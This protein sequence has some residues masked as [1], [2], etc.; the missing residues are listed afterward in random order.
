MQKHFIFFLIFLP[1][2]L[3][4]QITWVGPKPVSSGKAPDLAIDPNN[5]ELHVAAIYQG[6]IYTHLDQEG[7]QISQETVPNSNVDLGNFGFGPAIAVDQNGN[8][9]ICYRKPTP[10]NLYYTIY[11]TKKVNGSWST[12]LEIDANVSRGYVVRMAIDHNN[13]VHI[14]RGQSDQPGT[15]LGTFAYMQVQGETV[16]K[17]Q[18]F[19]G[20]FRA[21]NKME[22]DVDPSGGVHVIVGN[23]NPEH[24]P[25]DYYSSEGG[26]NNLAHVADI[27]HFN[28]YSRNGAPDVFVDMN[29]TIHFCYGTRYDSEVN[30]KG[31]IR[32]AQY[33]GGNKIN[34]VVVTPE[35]G[36]GSLLQWKDAPVYNGWGL[37]SLAASS[38][39]R[40]VVVAYL[41]KDKGPLY[42][43][44]SE[45]GG[46]TWSSPQYRAPAWDSFDGRNL[47]V[48]RGY[49]NNMYL[50]YQTST[51][52]IRVQYLRNIG[53]ALPT[54]SAGGDY[55]ALEGGKITFNATASADTGL[56]AGII[57]YEWDWENDG[58]YD[59]YSGLPTIER[60]YTDDYSG[61][62]RLR[63]TDRSGNQATDV[64]HVQISNIAPVVEAGD[65]W[66]IQEGGRVDLECTVQDPG[67]DTHTFRWDLGDGNT[68][69]GQ[70]VSHTYPDDG[71][72]TVFLTG[73]DDDGGED[74]DTLTVTVENIPPTAE[75]G[76]PYSASRNQDI[77]FVGSGQDAGAQDVLTYAWD[78][79]GDGDFEIPGTQ[80]TQSWADTGQFRVYF[81]V[82]DDDGGV[83]IDSAWVTIRG[84]KPTLLTIPDQ[85]TQ[86]GGIF[87]P[88]NLDNYISHPSQSAQDM[89]WWVTDTVLFS[90]S[91]DN[92]R[93]LVTF[94][95]PDWFGE[96]T[97]T[98]TVQD[99]GGFRD[100][101]K[102]TYRVL[103]VNDDPVWTQNPP[104][105]AFDEDASTK[106]TFKS[107]LPLVEDVDNAR[108]EFFFT[109]TGSQQIITTIDSS[110]GEVILSAGHNWHGSE[111]IQITV[112]DGSGG[113][114]SATSRV[115]VRPMPDA[116][117]T[118][119]VI[120]P[121]YMRFMV[122]PDTIHFRWH[123]TGDPDGDT[124]SRYI[125]E[126]APKEVPGNAETIRIDVLDTVF[127]FVP[128]ASVLPDGVWAWSAIARDASGL[129]TRCTEPGYFRKDYNPNAGV[130]EAAY[131]PK[132]LQLHQNYPNPFNP[133]T[134]IQYDLPKDMMVKL[135][136]YNSLGQQVVTLDSGLRNAGVHRIR[137]KAT[138]SEGNKVPSGIYI[139]RLTTEKQVLFRKLMLVQ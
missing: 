60:T 132:K 84:D 62:V 80:T 71:I 139:Y 128:D 99:L 115:T 107:L 82:A 75:A 54:A 27:H 126:L 81:R 22:I 103:N 51:P 57:R 52:T 48:I 65:D 105:Y 138:D 96:E 39:G 100:S 86:E 35:T 134:E 90:A 46:A 29:S 10:D 34:D 76:G 130:E 3:I 102:V 123:S 101:I 53:D 14:I 1:V 122:W 72:F 116:P 87:Q 114:A 104:S 91:I 20:D 79:D 58:V 45:D 69:S 118:F 68:R 85:V 93:L 136:I 98:I 108:S 30:N 61:N 25:V 109:V 64:A 50:V 77:Q 110:R 12:P 42:T 49:E 31:S 112:N 40:F 124:I 11:Y 16:R 74:R 70:A 15:V 44:H 47:H 36:T 106:F 125:W 83:A 19:I 4:S 97:L 24:G 26:F 120:E 56:N 127:T 119:D 129:E 89:L 21:D 23:P 135:K 133:E 55:A 59:V 41:R 113:S 18:T 2:L 5:G 17:R 43:V 9:H 7:E 37:S 95:E 78:L 117:Y 73:Q 88:L 121:E 137:W 131:L 8:P 6:V 28:A 94:D 67:A 111:N 33:Q 63:V 92:R 32:Y 13:V 38:E 66:L